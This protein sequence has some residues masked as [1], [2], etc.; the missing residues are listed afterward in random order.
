MQ[1]N[2]SKTIEENKN[3]IDTKF[4]YNKTFKRF[5]QKV[6]DEWIINNDIIKKII[7]EPTGFAILNGEADI[8]SSIISFTENTRILSITPTNEH[9]IFYV[10]GKEYIKTDVSQ[11][12]IA[13]IEGIHY[14]YFNNNGVLESKNDFSI[15]EITKKYASVATV[16]W[17]A[18]NKKATYIGDKRHSINSDAYQNYLSFINDKTVDY[19]EGTN[20]KFTNNKDGS[21]NNK[22]DGDGN[23][24]YHSSFAIEAGKYKNYDL[25]NDSEHIEFN[26]NI[27]VLYKETVSQEKN[28][29]AMASGASKIV[30][31]ADDGECRVM[32]STDEG[33]TWQ[34]VLLPFSSIWIDIIFAQNKFVAIASS[35]DYSVMTSTDGISWTPIVI[36]QKN[37]WQNIT[38][39]S[40]LDLFVVVGL[41]GI[42]QI[43]TSNNAV[44][45][46]MRA[47]P[48]FLPLK[49]IT[50]SSSGGN[51][52]IA[53]SE[54][55]ITALSTSANPDTVGF[56]K[57]FVS[58]NGTTWTNLNI[59]ETKTWRA[60]NYG[61]NNFI[62]LANSGKHRLLNSNIGNIWAA[63]E[64]TNSTIDSYLWTA[65][66]YAFGYHMAVSSDGKFA[67][68]LNGLNWETT[69]VLNNVNNTAISNRAWQ[70]LVAN[71]NTL[72]AT[73]NEA[74]TI[75][76][77]ITYSTN[78][79]Y[80]WATSTARDTRVI[81]D[82]V[83]GADRWVLVASATSD[84][85]PRIS[86]TQSATFASFTDYVTTGYDN[87]IAWQSVAY[88]NLTYVAVGSGGG[89][90]RIIFSTNGTSWSVS[91]NI[92]ASKDFV[93][94]KYL[95]NGFYLLSS[96]NIIYYS[97]TGTSNWFRVNFSS[98]ITSANL[99][100]TNF[101]SSPSM[102]VFSTTTNRVITTNL[103]FTSSSATEGSFGNNRLLNVI[104]NLSF[105]S[106]SNDSTGKM[107]VSTKQ[108]K[109]L[110]S[111]D[112]GVTWLI[113]DIN[114]S[115][116]NKVRYIANLTSFFLLGTAGN[117]RVIYSTAADLFNTIKKHITITVFNHS[118]TD[119]LFLNNNYYFLLNSGNF[120]IIK[121]STITYNTQESEISSFLNFKS[122]AKDVYNSWR[123]YLDTSGTESVK[124]RC[125]IFNNK[126]NYNRYLNGFYT[127]QICNDNKF[128]LYHVLMT[129]DKDNKY[130]IVTGNFE[131]DSKD[132]AKNSIL[133]E[134]NKLSGLPFNDFLL[135]GTII[136]EVNSSYTNSSKARIV[137]INGNNYYK[138]IKKDLVSISSTSSN[139]I[140]NVIVKKDNGILN[141]SDLINLYG[142][143][144]LEYALN[145]LQS[146]ANR[147]IDNFITRQEINLIAGDTTNISAIFGTQIT[148]SY[149]IFD[150]N[151]PEIG[152]ILFLKQNG[153]T[154]NPDVN[155]TSYS[156][157]ILP[158]K[159]ESS[160]AD[161]L[162]VYIEN[163]L[164]NFRNLS[165]STIN[166]VI[167]RKI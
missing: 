124:N 161:L 81:Q 158:S 71:A 107:V 111:S 32:Y 11:V 52:F 60:L 83:Y 47:T 74:T 93:R 163:F 86:F 90:N 119:L 3:L 75:T 147:D 40:S 53:V 144:V 105:S 120:R 38:Y 33:E 140:N 85:G 35:G 89:A 45:W 103:N 70:R 67:R 121:S 8:Y 157:L 128:Y 136:Y 16:Y 12:Q 19:I 23:S 148:A 88:G 2:V 97:A 4:I 164:L 149:E 78:G 1:F 167:Y 79:G 112:N 130:A 57:A 132:E 31:I 39:S 37:R 17:D 29:L 65:V 102:L 92:P 73:S 129:N 58:T 50:F 61:N 123:K 20:I 162:G 156:S 154:V 99:T 122:V 28:W 36:S 82:I 34:K 62:S 51:K 26:E 126:I 46:T 64:M 54:D 49:A 150:K 94:I 114:D 55:D 84:S 7:S 153:A 116:I 159:T 109:V 6:S 43:M 135:L 48:N 110:T 72:V 27:P 143:K 76:N 146:L 68:S 118:V 151:N 91:T 59:S 138:L 22:V 25:I 101:T 69:W 41:D 104:D 115:K 63:Y 152:M 133:E 13:D 56:S 14:V 160:N 106:I 95:Q 113:R 137:N 108:N 139:V 96:D 21:V 142:N 145:K 9:F 134:I 44:T 80:T 165:D 15:S 125:L 131:Y 77:K 66:I 24:N 87:T 30:A 155:I 127:L 117:N 42:N 10:N 18:I 166:L 141:N 98:E 5:E 100:I